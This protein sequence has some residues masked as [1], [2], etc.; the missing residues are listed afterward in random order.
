MF[1]NVI[2]GVEGREGVDAT[3]LAARSCTA[4]V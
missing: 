4:A 2:V 3:A 1:E